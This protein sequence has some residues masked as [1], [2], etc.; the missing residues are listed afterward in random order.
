M[1]TLNFSIQI[2][3]SEEAD[4]AAQELAASTA[5]ANWLSTRKFTL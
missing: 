5:S 3:F 1:K 4:K 2:I